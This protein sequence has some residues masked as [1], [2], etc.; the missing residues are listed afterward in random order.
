[1]KD[2]EIAA[3]LQDTE[4]FRDSQEI[5]NG[6]DAFQGFGFRVQGFVAEAENKGPSGYFNAYIRVL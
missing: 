4:L 6:V 1:M 3:M 2:I 5:S